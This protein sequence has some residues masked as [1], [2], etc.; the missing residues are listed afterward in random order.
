MDQWNDAFRCFLTE[1]IAEVRELIGNIETQVQQ[2]SVN[3]G[4]RSQGSTESATVPASSIPSAKLQRDT[5]LVGVAPEPSE[6]SGA[7]V[8]ERDTIASFPAAEAPGSATFD[9]RL[10]QLARRLEEKLERSG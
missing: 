7:R 2:G 6:W 3:R 4:E 9:D 10:A 1:A 5:R 8:D